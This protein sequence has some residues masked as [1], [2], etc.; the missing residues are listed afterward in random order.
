MKSCAIL[1][2]FAQDQDVNHLFIQCIH[3]VHIVLPISHLVAVLVN[4]NDS[5]RTAG[6]VL[7]NFYFTSL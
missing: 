2:H 6:P 3:G 5:S 1:L 4:L 7:S